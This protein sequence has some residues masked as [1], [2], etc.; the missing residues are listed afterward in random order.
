MPMM[1]RLLP[2]SGSP[3]AQMARTSAA[4]RLGVEV[5]IAALEQCFARTA[6][7]VRRTRW[8]AGR[9]SPLSH[10]EAV[11]LVGSSVRRVAIVGGLRIPFAR[12]MGAY[13][14][15]SNQEMLTATLAAL[16]ER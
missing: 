15:A 3:S 4:K 13:A 5:V 7:T 11:M 1:D 10:S 16:V 2:S 12:S 14:E 9:R 8:H 6:L